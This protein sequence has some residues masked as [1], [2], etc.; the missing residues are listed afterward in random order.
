M[1]KMLLF[2]ALLMPC[3][4]FADE[5]GLTIADNLDSP[6][7]AVAK[8]N[9]SDCQAKRTEGAA[10][11]PDESWPIKTSA[12]VVE[13]INVFFSGNKPAIN[14]LPAAFS[15]D[16][17]TFCSQM[18]LEKVY[19]ALQVIKKRGR[20]KHKRLIDD[21]MHIVQKHMRPGMH[22]KKPS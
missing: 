8:K 12:E 11:N 21:F 22:S 13:S 15:N 4:V 14:I 2:I 7:T 6:C 9:R 3:L 1:K 17:L 18:E 5:Y 20:Y 19:Q 16:R 10:C